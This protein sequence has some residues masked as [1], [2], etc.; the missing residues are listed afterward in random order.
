MVTLLATSL[1]PLCADRHPPK[2]RG[3]SHYIARPAHD[4]PEELGPRLS[5]FT[6]APRVSS[7]NCSCAPCEER[8]ASLRDRVARGLDSL[9]ILTP[10]KN[11][12]CSYYDSPPCCI[13]GTF[14]N[15]LLRQDR[16]RP[17]SEAFHLSA[18]VKEATRGVP[19]LRESAAVC[20]CA[21]FVVR[22]LSFACFSSGNPSRTVQQ[23]GVSFLRSFFFGLRFIMR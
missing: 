16:S 7:P 20:A 6:L 2:R 13:F 15:S 5:L 23:G 17:L 22:L 4:Q 12:C 19:V 11:R 3:L 18:L 10:D 9:L 14:G 1:A 21:S 8:C